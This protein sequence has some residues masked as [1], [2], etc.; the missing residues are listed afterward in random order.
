MKQ[1]ILKFHKRNSE[2]TQVG[3]QLFSPFCCVAALCSHLGLED[4]QTANLLLAGGKKEILK[5]NQSEGMFA[6]YF[7]D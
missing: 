3:S 1:V 2:V 7:E 6:F 4:C 5:E